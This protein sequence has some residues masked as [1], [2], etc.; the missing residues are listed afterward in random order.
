MAKSMTLM[1]GMIKVRILNKQAVNQDTFW[2]LSSNAGNYKKAINTLAR[3]YLPSL[4]P[5]Y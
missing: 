4:N 3:P 1:N 5:N 2:L